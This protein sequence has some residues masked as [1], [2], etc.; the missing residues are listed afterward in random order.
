MTNISSLRK[1]DLTVFFTIVEELL[2]RFCHVH[3]DN[4]GSVK[5]FVEEIHAIFK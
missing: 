1:S 5:A 3:D 2:K 4:V